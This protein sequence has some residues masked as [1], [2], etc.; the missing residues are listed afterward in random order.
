MNKLFVALVIVLMSASVFSQ[1]VGQAGDS[2]V[3]Y[4]DING[5]KQ[6]VWKKT[7]KSGQLKYEAYFL[8]DKPVGD[9]KR[10]DTY[11]KLTA[12]LVY[13]SVGEKASATLYHSSTKV[14]ATGF[15]VGKTKDGIWKYYDENG[16]HYLQESFKVGVKHGTFLQITSEGVAIEELNWVDGVK[17]GKW[18]KRFVEGQP[19][20][21]ANYV[22]G[23]L[24]GDTKTYY[25][26][27][28][29][30]KEGKFVDDLMHGPWLKYNE[31]GNLIKVYQYNKGRSPEAE[32]EQQELLDELEQGKGNYDGPKNSDDI[33]WLRGRSN[34]Y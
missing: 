23:K 12:H 17:H 32:K 8:N 7:H 15:Y 24:Q 5:F 20:W 14:A 27:G 3:N 22:H 16:I 30:H 29:L 6:G 1:N 10:Y 28:K 26:N 31:N 2:L 13:D 4:T 33:D 34:G 21:E 25:K 11:G 19:M 9:L 18:I